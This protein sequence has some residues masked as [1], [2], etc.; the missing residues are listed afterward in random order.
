M[1]RIRA[2]H[3]HVP[4][5]QG[6]RDN[7]RSHTPVSR[8]PVDDH[9]Q[10]ALDSWGS[11]GN[12]PMASRFRPPMPSFMGH[13]PIASMME[14]QA[15]M[16]YTYMSPPRGPAFNFGSPFANSPAPRMPMARLPLLFSNLPLIKN[17]DAPYSALC[18][19]RDKRGNHNQRPGWHPLNKREVLDQCNMLFQQYPD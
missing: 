19:C 4:A 11:M 14:I 6:P 2:E 7:R 9:D 10:Q 13:D 16:G 17:Q 3:P 15:T 8:P 18:R 5:P 1:H 12:H